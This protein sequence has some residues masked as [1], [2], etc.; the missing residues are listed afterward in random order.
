MHIPQ[1]MAKERAIQCGEGTTGEEFDNPPSASAHHWMHPDHLHH[2]DSGTLATDLSSPNCAY[3]ADCKELFEASITEFQDD[4]KTLSQARSHSNWPKW[5]NVMDRE[6]AM[7]EKAGT[8]T[9]IP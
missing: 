5:K 4:P 2:Y 9:N 1:L 8:W 3:L 7:L 6:I